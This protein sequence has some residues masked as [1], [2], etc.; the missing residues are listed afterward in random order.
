MS[1]EISA[2]LFDLVLAVSNVIDLLSTDVKEHHARVACV[3]LAIAQEMQFGAEDINDLVLA[4]LLHDVGI[5]T[6]EERAT[7]LMFDSRNIDAHANK[8]W[9]LLRKFR[10][11]ANVAEIVRNHHVAWSDC[12]GTIKVGVACDSVKEQVG[13][14]SH[15]LHLADRITILVGNPSPDVLDI[16]DVVVSSVQHESG[17]K[18]APHVVDAFVRLSRS[19]T[20][21]LDMISPHISRKIMSNISGHD[22]ELCDD[23]LHDFAKL[24]AQI[25]D[26]RCSF[27]ATHSNSVSC[28]A[29]KLASLNGMTLFECNKIKLAGYL[30]DIGKLAI[31]REILEKNS[32][33]TSREYSKMRTHVYYTRDVLE[34]IAGFEDIVAWASQHHE[35]LDGSGYPDGCSGEKITLGAR[36]VAAADVFA[37]L[38]EVRP[39]RK[40]KTRQ[41]VITIMMA[42]ADRGL[43]DFEI[44]SLLLDNFEVVEAERQRASEDV[45]VAYGEYVTAPTITIQSGMVSSDNMGLSFL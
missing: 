30:H 34:H 37:A 19:D 18:F 5:I 8:G 12:A 11:L 24:M 45:A 2:S 35:R 17:G 21:W 43:I 4:A 7:V 20:F 1:E 14:L 42:M 32:A 28:V 40:G 13:L 44:V 25:I 23:D 41:E 29:A 15:I 26:F 3:S 27:T 10:H 31:P 36:I 22:V 38:S 39:Y 16:I 33:L 9:I 6:S